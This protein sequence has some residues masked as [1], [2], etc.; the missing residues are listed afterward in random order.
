MR[1]FRQLFLGFHSELLRGKP[2]LNTEDQNWIYF[3]IICSSEHEEILGTAAK[4]HHHNS[5]FL[6]RPSKKLIL[7]PEKNCAKLFSS[8][9]TANISTAQS[10]VFYC[11]QIGMYFPCA[12]KSAIKPLLLM[13]NFKQTDPRNCH[14]LW[15]LQA[16]FPLFMPSPH[17]FMYSQTW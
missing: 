9:C 5:H 12:F 15:F 4:F 2:S 3:S 10:S 1:V 7:G 8:S 14:F 6:I 17:Y 11:V 16:C 13:K